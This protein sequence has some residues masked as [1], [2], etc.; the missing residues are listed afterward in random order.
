MKTK[1]KIFLF[2]ETLMCCSI[3]FSQMNK[4]VKLKNGSELRGEIL[5]ISDNNIKLKTK[6]GNI[7][8]FQEYEIDTCFSFKARNFLSHFY[9]S[10]TISCLSGQEKKEGGA[11]RF[12]FQI[13]SGYNFKNRLKIGLGLGKQK[14]DV[15]YFY[16]YYNTLFGELQYNILKT[17][18]TPFFNIMGGIVDSSRDFDYRQKGGMLGIYTGINHYFSKNLGITTSI[19]YRFLQLNRGSAIGST[20]DK[21]DQF[22]I[23]F[24]LIFN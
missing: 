9:S 18:N 21:Y 10:A 6:D 16:T 17:Q 14:Y 19:G 20:I 3:G 7:W 23:R 4:V 24:G 11:L 8:V 2:L 12:S 1:I 15:Y 5:P 13:V 22:E